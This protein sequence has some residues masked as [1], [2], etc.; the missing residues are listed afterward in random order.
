MDDP[1]SGAPA[2][3]TATNRDVLRER[4]FM[5]LKEGALDSE[6]KEELTDGN[7]SWAS[8]SRGVRMVVETSYNM[9]QVLESDPLPSLLSIL[10]AKKV[11][12]I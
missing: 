4:D 7:E 5:E 3:I 10:N 11:I 9:R 12:S 8:S 1:V 2:A 6:A